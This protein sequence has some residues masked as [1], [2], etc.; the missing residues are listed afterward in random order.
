MCI[1]RFVMIVACACLLGCFAVTAGCT[2]AQRARIWA[3]MNDPNNPGKQMT[4]AAED[5][6]TP[7][8]AGVRTGMEILGLALAAGWSVVQRRETTKLAKEKAGIE[9][10][11]DAANEDR[12]HLEKLHQETRQTLRAIVQGVQAA[13]KDQAAPVK[14]SIEAKMKDAKIFDVANAI[15]DEIKLS[16]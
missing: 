14:S 1:R 16:A 2:A 4:D 3:G 8:P 11:R 13:P 12:E 7:M 5:P 15:V 10:A 6:A 9:W